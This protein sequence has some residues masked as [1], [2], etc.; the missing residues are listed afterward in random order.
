MKDEDEDEDEDEEAVNEEDKP[1]D[2]D[3]DENVEMMM[4]IKDQKKADGI[5]VNCLQKELRNSIGDN[6]LFTFSK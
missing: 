2:E 1:S 3:E 4:R 5:K 6:F